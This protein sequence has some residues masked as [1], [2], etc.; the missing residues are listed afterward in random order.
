ME[1]AGIERGSGPPSSEIRARFVALAKERGIEIPDRGNSEEE[2][3]PEAVR[4]QTVYKL[5]G[6][7][8]NPEIVPVMVKLGIT[9]AITTEVLDGLEDDDVIVTSVLIPNR[10]FDS[11]K[12]TTNPFGSNMRR[13]R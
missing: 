4:T 2:M 9:D 10:D 3:N 12:G 7:A 13:Q 1:D 6:T 11:G 5:E 8:A